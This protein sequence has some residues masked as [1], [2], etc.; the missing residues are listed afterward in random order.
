ML[1]TS[2]ASSVTGCYMPLCV[3]QPSL[4]AAAMWYGPVGP[5]AVRQGASLTS[6]HSP[7][8]CVLCSKD[9]LQH[10]HN[11]II[12]AC[13]L[14]KS[15]RKDWPLLFQKVKIYI[16]ANQNISVYQFLMH[17][18]MYSRH[19]PENL[20]RSG[21]HFLVWC[22]FCTFHWILWCPADPH[23]LWI[24]SNLTLARTRLDSSGI[25]ITATGQLETTKSPSLL[26]LHSIWAAS[27]V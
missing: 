18:N 27:A 13:S 2:E 6:P 26:C 25:T 9:L 3:T 5:S 16:D 4:S 23:L 8:L 11:I 22:H 21:T 24:C 1:L 15:F 14:Q 20:A 12:V 10:K 17:C 7:L 19:L